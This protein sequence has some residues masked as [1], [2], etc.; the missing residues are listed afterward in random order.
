MDELRGKARNGVRQMKRL[1]WLFRRKAKATRGARFSGSEA[2]QIEAWLRSANTDREAMGKLL[3]FVDESLAH[4][5]S[6][7]NFHIVGQRVP[8]QRR[9][10]RSS[11]SRTTS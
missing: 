9:G 6:R 10:W 4:V 11:K 1:D 5:P 8:L 2:E 3:E 7:L